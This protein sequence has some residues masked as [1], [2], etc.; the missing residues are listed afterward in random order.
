MTKSHQKSKKTQKNQNQS[1]MAES[2]GIQAIANHPVI[3]TTT[4]LMKV[5]RDADTKSRTV[6]NTVNPRE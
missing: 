2:E 5:L 3:Q 4:A 1:E 6:A